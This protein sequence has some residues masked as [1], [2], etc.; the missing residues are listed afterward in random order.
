MSKIRMSINELNEM[1]EFYYSIG[2]KYIC[3]RSGNS[4]LLYVN[5]SCYYASIL[6]LEKLKIEMPDN[7]IYFI[8]KVKRYIERNELVKKIKPN[9]SNVE[10][11]KFFD[12]NKY[13]H[14]V[15]VFKNSFS[16]DISKAYF[17]SALL[18]GWINEELYE[19]GLG[20]SKQI[21]LASL[22]SFAKN[23]DVYVFNGKVEKFSHSI[24]PKYP[25]VFFNQANDVYRLMNKCKN[26]IT[27][28][29]GFL[30]YWT[31]GLYV[32]GLDN[33]AL[34]EGIIDGAGHDSKTSRLSKIIRNSSAF[35][36]SEKGLRDKNY[37]I[38]AAAVKLAI[39]KHY[40]GKGKK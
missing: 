23:T 2:K 12:Y 27:D 16:V 24:K 21:R 13:I 8:S 35:I 39:N 14:P 40:E 4:K 30:F 9:Y 17:K 3:H 36:V 1:M 32:Q 29:N 11:I 10:K 20:I 6:N 19:E 38:E 7:E 28:V 33:A 15:S 31:D 25:H 34:C 37:P 5:G 18:G 26:A 22:G